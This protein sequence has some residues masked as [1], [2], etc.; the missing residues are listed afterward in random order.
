MVCYV[1][2]FRGLDRAYKARIPVH[3]PGAG[4]RM[5][6]RKPIAALIV[7]SVSS[8]GGKK[9]VSFRGRKVVID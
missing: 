4:P 5:N 6:G 9:V 1:Y 7:D 3:L 8:E 2:T